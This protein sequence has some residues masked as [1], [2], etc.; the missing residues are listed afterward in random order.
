MKM[1]TNH[2]PDP[3]PNPKFICNTFKTYFVLINSFLEL[4]YF[5]KKPSNLNES[6]KQPCKPYRTPGSKSSQRNGNSRV[7]KL[8]CET[9]DHSGLD[10]KE[11]KRQE[12]IYELFQGEC[13]I[14]QDLKLAK[15]V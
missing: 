2:N 12:A 5:R 11:L 3:N 13:N 9:Y 10:R 7:S 15:Q 8:W 6:S 1:N 4:L 14:V